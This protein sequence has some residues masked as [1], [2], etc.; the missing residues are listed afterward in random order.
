MQEA[1]KAMQ[2]DVASIEQIN[3]GIRI[4]NDRVLPLVKTA[5]GQDFGTIRTPGRGGGPTNWDTLINRPRR[6]LSQFIRDVLAFTPIQPVLHHAC[7][8]AGTPVRTIDGPEADRIADGGRSRALPGPDHRRALVPAGV[9][10][11]PQPPLAALE[12]VDG[13]GV[14]PRHRASI[15]SGR[16]ARGGRWRAT[17]SPATS[18]ARWAGR[19]H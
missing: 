9:A 13:L 4:V 15:G 7:F 14:R 5:T 11:S 17:S 10:H 1:A 18:S 16:S 3:Q 6:R 2:Q 12:A 19:S 8:A